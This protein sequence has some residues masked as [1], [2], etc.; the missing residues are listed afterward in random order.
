M[1]V[2]DRMGRES[3]V[4]HQRR[5]QAELESE[6]RGDTLSYKVRTGPSGNLRRTCLLS[7]E[8][9]PSP[10]LAG[11]RLGTDF[12]LIQTWTMRDPLA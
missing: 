7:N 6:C 9:H 10:S 11:G 5:P 12:A 3:V 2:E 8:H 4:R 1:V